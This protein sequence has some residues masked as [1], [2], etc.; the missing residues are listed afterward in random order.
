VDRDLIFHL[1]LAADWEA[2]VP[3]GAYRISTIGRSLDEVGFIHC[4]HAEQVA[5]TAAAFYL[6]RDDVL[7]LSIDPSLLDAAVHVE[8][9]FPHI[10]GPVPVAAVVDV[11]PLDRAVS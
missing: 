4:S 10:Y 11:T 6:G 8:G 9:G 5:P 7:V 2:A 3:T 1:A